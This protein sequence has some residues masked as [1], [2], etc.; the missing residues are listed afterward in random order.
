M[1]AANA[2][3]GVARAAYF[4]LF[5]IPATAGFESTNITNWL[6]GPS[7]FA[8]VGISATITALDFGRRHAASDQA[9]ASYN[10]AAAAYQQTVL[11]AYQEVEDFL[12]ALRLLSDEARTQAAAV[13]AAER[14]LALSENRYKGGVTSY[15]EVTTAQA[16][17]LS[18]ER[19]AVQL[20]GR[21]MVDSVLLVKAL[22][23]GFDAATLSSLNYNAPTP[24]SPAP[25]TSTNAP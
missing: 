22:G 20:A 16:T 14:S 25:S 17:A 21:R 23:G 13:A 15:L 18:N 8:A 2:N 11:T 5:S 19:T 7:G 12:A 10:Q 6:T 4:P 1:A 24:H 3:I 9:W